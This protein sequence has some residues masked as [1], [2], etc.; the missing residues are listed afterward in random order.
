LKRLKST[1]YAVAQTPLRRY[2]VRNCATK[3]RPSPSDRLCRLD[4]AAYNHNTSRETAERSLRTA[5][6]EKPIVPARVFFC[7]TLSRRDISLLVPVHTDDSHRRH[8]ST[9]SLH[10]NALG[11]TSGLTRVLAPFHLSDHQLKRL[12]HVLVVARARFRP[13]TLELFGKGSAIF[14]SDLTLFRAEIGFVAYND[15]GNPFDG[16]DGAHG[17]VFAMLRGVEAQRY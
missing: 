17:Q 4:S 2:V 12:Q 14:G 10:D 9:T 7:L 6:V 11:T 5:L 13:G 16:L 15:E 8:I 1:Y 3:F